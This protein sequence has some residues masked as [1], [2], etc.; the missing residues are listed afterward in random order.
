[1][2]QII[3]EI[4]DI[5]ISDVRFKIFKMAVDWRRKL[6][7]KKRGHKVEEESSKY[8]LVSEGTIRC[9]LN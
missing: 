9:G 7:G 8:V 5:L 2:S 4:F 6:G 1:M 3:F